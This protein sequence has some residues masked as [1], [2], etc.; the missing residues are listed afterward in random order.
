[1]VTG[2]DWQN[3][4]LCAGLTVNR[5]PGLIYFES[6]LGGMLGVLI[7]NLNQLTTRGTHTYQQNW[8]TLSLLL[9]RN[10]GNAGSWGAECTFSRLLLR[11]S[12]FRGQAIDPR[13][14]RNSAV[15][16]S[17]SEA[18]GWSCSHLSFCCLCIKH[19][20]VLSPKAWLV[21]TKKRETLII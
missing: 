11:A 6:L 17:D 7:R 20:K 13:W 5:K 21:E 14:K 3:L 1:M 18:A 12:G 9:I 2:A 8:C 15:Q 4:S 10:Q 16:S 19:R